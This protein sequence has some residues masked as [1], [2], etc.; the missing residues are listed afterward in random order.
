MRG[1]IKGE[2]ERIIP[3][4]YFSLSRYFI[5]SA[6]SFHGR[7]SVSLPFS[8]FRLL[9]RIS[10]CVLI[11]TI[12]RVCGINFQRRLSPPLFIRRSRQKGKK[13]RARLFLSLSLFD[14]SHIQ[15]FI[16]LTAEC[17]PRLPLI[18]IINFKCQSTVYYSAVSAARDITF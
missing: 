16:P 9:R 3:L 1:K 6:W 4:R 18:S 2:T 13:S 12:S 10:V 11:Y 15:R 7:F 8:Q 17:A 5:F 14:V